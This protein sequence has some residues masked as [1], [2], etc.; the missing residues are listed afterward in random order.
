V[1]VVY[2]VRG[3]EVNTELRYSLRTLA[4]LEHERVWIVGFKPSWVSDDVGYIEGNTQGNALANYY[5]NILA[6]C[7]TEEISDPFLL[8]ND[9]FFVTGPVS[10]ELPVYHAGPMGKQ[11]LRRGRVDWWSKALSRTL[12]ALKAEGIEHPTSYELHLPLPIAKAPCEIA[13]ERMIH[14]HRA[15]CLPRSVYGNLA[16]IGGQ[17]TADVKVWRSSRINFPLHSTQDSSWIACAS[18]FRRHFKAPCGY[19]VTPASSASVAR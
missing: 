12:G 1:D 6:A 18:F 13:L 9:D 14:P 17:Q 19:E 16:G 8:F 2:A 11:L 4:N 10:G 5:H 3:G 7:M 15:L